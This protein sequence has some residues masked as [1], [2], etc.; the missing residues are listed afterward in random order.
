MRIQCAELIKS[1]PSYSYTGDPA[2]DKNA[3]KGWDII[4]CFLTPFPVP[5]SLPGLLKFFCQL[6]S[7][8][9]IPILFISQNCAIEP[10]IDLLL[11]PPTLPVSEAHSELG[12]EQKGKVKDSPPPPEKNVLRGGARL[13]ERHTPMGFSTWS[14]LT[15]SFQTSQGLATHIQPWSRSKESSALNKLFSMVSLAAPPLPPLHQEGS[16][17]GAGCCAVAAV[18]LPQESGDPSPLSF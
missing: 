15:F 14:F 7:S 6:I 1:I 5:P 17:E 8:L 11:L 10:Y 4:L 13:G 9:Q 16:A 18:S 3:S 2:I 12:P